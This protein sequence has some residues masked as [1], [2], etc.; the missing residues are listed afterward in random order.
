MK[1]M[2][3]SLLLDFYG[4]LLNEKQLSMMEEYYQEDLSLSEIAEN[5]GITRQG[6]HDKI[7]RGGLELKSYEER[8]GLLERFSGITRAADQIDSMLKEGTVIDAKLYGEI[9][10]LLDIIRNEA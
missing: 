5:C 9:S 2:S 8:L 10:R 1:D 6:V 7:R 4:N 3:I